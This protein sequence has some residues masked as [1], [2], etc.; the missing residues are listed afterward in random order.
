MN[1]QGIELSN[2]SIKIKEFSNELIIVEAKV[3]IITLLS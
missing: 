3:D 2:I 1:N